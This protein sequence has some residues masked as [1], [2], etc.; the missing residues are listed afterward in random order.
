MGWRVIIDQQRVRRRARPGDPH[1]NGERERASERE[2]ERTSVFEC[3]RERDNRG[4][5]RRK[6]TLAV[7]SIG[8][9]VGGFAK[10]PGERASGGV[11]LQ[12]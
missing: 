6:S 9:G 11:A 4:G 10:T 3:V 12:P 1:P 5:R 7:S 2:R 8:N